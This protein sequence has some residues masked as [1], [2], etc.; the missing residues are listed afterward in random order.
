[1]EGKVARK[2]KKKGKPIT[3]MHVQILIFMAV[4]IAIGSLLGFFYFKNLFQTYLATQHKYIEQDW[5]KVEYYANRITDQVIKFK[6]M[7]VKD[8]IK[9][10]KSKMDKVVNIRAR[11][12]GADSLEEKTE[13]LIKLEGAFTKVMKLYN[14]RTD[15][16]NKRFGYI[17]W[18]MITAEY[19]DAYNDH[20]NRYIDAAADFN[21][22][23]KKIPFGW[24]KK[25]GAFPLA[26]IGELKNVTVNTEKYQKDNIY[27]IDKLEDSSSAGSY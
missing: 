16:R 17:E 14:S 18:G 12:L 9:I 20:K 10:S 2:K 22:K 6:K 8:K 26:E 27:R 24:G 3:I 21:D 25:F 15:L 4:G 23:I 11:M 19:I 5:S 1:M 13:Q 7:V